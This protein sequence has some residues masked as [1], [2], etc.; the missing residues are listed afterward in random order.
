MKKQ[1]ISSIF[2]AGVLTA[3]GAIAAEDYTGYSNEELFE[4]R[5]Q[6]GMMNEEDRQAYRT[7]RKNRM[8][9]MSQ[10]ERQTMNQNHGENAGSGNGDRDRV[11]SRDGSG[12][13]NQNGNG[14]RMKLRDGSGGGKQHGSQ[15][16]GGQGKG[17]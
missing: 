11:Q 17:R 9:N 16:G 3:T 8:Q 6:V 14:D 5:G 7:E 10:E 12:S 2:I 4:M 13:G 15:G 1:L